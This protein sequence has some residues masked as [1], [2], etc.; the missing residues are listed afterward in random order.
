VPYGCLSLPFVAWSNYL[1]IVEEKKEEKEMNARW[2]SPVKEIL[3][4]SL[5]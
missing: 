4:T 3:F 5:L 2:P 1:P